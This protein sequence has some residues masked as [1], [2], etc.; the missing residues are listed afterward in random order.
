MSGIIHDHS[1][2]GPTDQIGAG[3]L[4]TVDKRLAALNSVREGRI[5]DVS[6]SKFNDVAEIMNPRIARFGLRFQ[7]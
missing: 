2:W 3:N 5:Y 1:R 7:F 4:L 6:S